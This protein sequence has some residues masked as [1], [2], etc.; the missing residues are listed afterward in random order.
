MHSTW[1]GTQGRNNHNLW[2]GKFSDELTGFEEAWKGNARKKMPGL[3]ENY[4]SLEHMGN[5]L[6]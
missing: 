5:W 3:P 6:A 4:L 2:I 1:V